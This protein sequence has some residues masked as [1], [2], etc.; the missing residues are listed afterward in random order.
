MCLDK[1]GTHSVQAIIE[2]LLTKEE[3]DFIV[4]EIQGHIS[5]LS[6]VFYKIFIA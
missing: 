6:T 3:E 4:S 2:M 1:Q 5:E